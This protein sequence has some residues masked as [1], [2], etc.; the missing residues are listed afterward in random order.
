MVALLKCEMAALQ[1]KVFSH[2]GA[3]EDSE[4]ITGS[5]REASVNCGAAWTQQDTVLF[6]CEERICGTFHCCVE[7]VLGTGGHGHKEKD[8]IRT[9]IAGKS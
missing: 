2:P 1:K 9:P 5:G 3:W 6:T 4:I 7:N 8:R